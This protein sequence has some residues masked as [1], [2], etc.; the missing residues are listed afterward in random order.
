MTLTF[1]LDLNLKQVKRQG[2][3]WKPHVIIFYNTQE[4]AVKANFHMHNV[5]AVLLWP[6]KYVKVHHLNKLGRPKST[7]SIYAGFM[8]EAAVPS[9]KKIFLG[10]WTSGSLWPW[11]KVE[12]NDLNKIEMARPKESSDQVSMKLAWWF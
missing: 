11:L 2:Q 7:D 4:I 10:F 1:D 5:E 3:K 8:S 12:V 6:W 9:E